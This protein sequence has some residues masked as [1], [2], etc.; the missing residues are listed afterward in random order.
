MSDPRIAEA[1]PGLEDRVDRALSTGDNGDIDILGYGEISSV[2]ACETGAGRFACKRLP[3]FHSAAPVA[4]YEALFTEY[5]QRLRDVGVHPVQSELY[6]VER[7]DGR[8]AVYCVQP[9]LTG[10]LGATLLQDTPVT[11]GLALFELLLDCIVGACRDGSGIDAQLANWALEDGELVY[12][13]VTTPFLRDEEGRDRLDTDI[14]VASLPWALRRPVQ[15]LAVHG[16]LSKW[17]EPRGALLDLLGN[18]IKE[19]LDRW[20]P[21]FVSATNR[22][23]EPLGARPIT[24]RE[25]ESYYRSDARLWGL[26]QWL[27]RADRAW[28][29][30]VRRRP[31]Q[32]LLPGKIERNV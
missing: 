26:L 5:L 3:L 12:M 32:F 29:R 11:E 16:I 23:L 19:R 14:F 20:L 18:L 25:V 9:I 28:Q 4:A 13:D 8:I 21:S 30:R 22:R 1:L 31:Y 6:R 10:P 17:Y 27:R 24:L 2:L 15:S 7:S